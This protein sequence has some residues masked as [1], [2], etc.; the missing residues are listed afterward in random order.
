MGKKTE[1]HAVTF[2]RKV[3]DEQAVA[4]TGKSP[5]E[6]IAFF[7]DAARKLP[8]RPSRSK[9]THRQAARPRT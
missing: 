3:R 6:I 4:L 1:F 5:Q 7:A 8:R 9:G 2:F